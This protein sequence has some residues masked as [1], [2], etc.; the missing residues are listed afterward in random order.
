MLPVGKIKMS[1][2]AVCYLLQGTCSRLDSVNGS[3]SCWSCNYC[4]FFLATCEYLQFTSYT[5]VYYMHIMIISVHW[6]AN[7]LN[8]ELICHF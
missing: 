6:M 8:L 1:N 2:V 4:S 5:T 3:L 7:C